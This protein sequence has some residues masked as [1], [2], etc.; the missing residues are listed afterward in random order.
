MSYLVA[1]T[2]DNHL[3]EASTAEIPL[4]KAIKQ[5]NQQYTLFETLIMNNYRMR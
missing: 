1:H 5:L 3:K 2:A 4:N